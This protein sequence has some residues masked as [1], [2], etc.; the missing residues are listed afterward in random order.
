ELGLPRLVL[1]VRLDELSLARR[2][3]RPGLAGR[4][5]GGGE[6]RRLLLDRRLAPREL[7]R[8]HRLPRVELVERALPQ[9]ELLLL[10]RE[11]VL[12]LARVRLGLAGLAHAGL[13]RRGDRVELA[14]PDLRGV[15]ARP[16][17]RL[18]LPLRLR[19]LREL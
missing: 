18:E 10:L 15:L 6:L 9:R 17:A 19:R 16:E 5:P 4:L 12:E 1:R 13:D 7:L 8:Q 3:L 2:Q 14:L 11:L